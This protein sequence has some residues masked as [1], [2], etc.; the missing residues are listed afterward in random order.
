MKKMLNKLLR[1]VRGLTLIEV[2]VSMTIFLIL[3]LGLSSILIH[4]Y[5]TVV[6]AGQRSDAVQASQQEME[7]VLADPEYDCQDMERIEDY[8]LHLFG[9]VIRG[10]LITMEKESSQEPKR[11]VTITIFV[12][13]E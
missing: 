5:R 6:Q 7:S 10:E 4:S 1:N 11:Q 9:T 3:A 2:L 13:Y 8:E 12:P